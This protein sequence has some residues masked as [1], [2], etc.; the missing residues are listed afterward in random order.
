LLSSRSHGTELATA[1][2]YSQSPALKLVVDRPAQSKLATGDQR[3][4]PKSKV[5]WDALHA[6]HDVC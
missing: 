1:A 4:R 3:L 6:G 2:Q 5:A